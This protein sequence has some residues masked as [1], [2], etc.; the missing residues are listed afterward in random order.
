MMMQVLEL[1]IEEHGL[2]TERVGN[3][4]QPDG[5][6]IRIKGKRRTKFFFT[7]AYFDDATT[8]VLKNGSGRDNQVKYDLN[9]PNSIDRLFTRLDSLARRAGFRPRRK[10]A[11]LTTPAPS[12]TGAK[13][14]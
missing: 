3:D 7:I 9:D 12:V 1:G 2:F 5:F 10:K 13:V 8:L 6:Y 11:E 4:G 14:G